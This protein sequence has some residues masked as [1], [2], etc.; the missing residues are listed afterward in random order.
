EFGKDRTRIIVTELP[1]QVNKR[2][3]ISAIAE[4]VK[5]KRIEGISDL[6]DESDRSGMRIVIELK[7]DANAQVVLNQLL[8][9]T[10]MQTT[11]SVNLLALVDNQSQPRILSLRHIIDEYL[12]FQIELIERRT[13]YDLKKAK[14]RAHLLEGLIIAQNN[15]EEVVR[16]IRESYDNAKQNLCDRFGLDDIQAQAILDMR[17]KQIQGLDREK[18]ENEY[19]ELQ[20][21]IAYYEGLL[22]DPEKIKG[23]LKDELIAIRD[24]YGDDRVTEI[25]DV[26]NEIDI[27]DLIPEEECVITLTHYGYIKRQPTDTYKTQ[28]RGGRGITGMTRREEDFVTELFICSTHEY[29]MFFTNRGRVYRLKGY[30]IAESSR[31]S[32]GTN[33]VN[34]LPL[35]SGEKVT[36]TIK[37][38]SFDEEKFLCMVTRN[39]VIKRTELS[40]F[41][42]IRKS[43]L[44]AINL[45]ENDELAWVRMTDGEDQL[46]IATEQGRAIRF[47][48]TEARGMG[49]TARGVRAISLSEGDQVIGMARVREGATL[50]TV[51]QDGHGRRT[52][53]E[54]YPIRSRGGKGVLNY[55]VEKNGPVAGIKSV[56]DTDD[57]FLISDDGVIIRINVSDVATQSRYGGGVRVMRLAEGSKVVTVARAPAEESDEVAEGEENSEAVENMEEISNSPEAPA[58]E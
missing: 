1:Y 12:K 36:S 24:K 27:E 22:A 3:L 17:L 49:R 23:V 51:S 19:K 38:G 57:A 26:E 8:T 11:F 4:H 31:T 30:E 58:E 5:D 42:N 9:Q 32:K 54:D 41:K 18:L 34:L 37:V 48:E 33:I 7:R 14:E 16:I 45:D 40:A 2:L 6:R 56:D 39:G 28:R 25:Q 15:I 55:Y 47:N 46:I 50:L 20:E 21:R 35:E 53:I 44:I 52:E 43:G 13:R 10:Q 29:I